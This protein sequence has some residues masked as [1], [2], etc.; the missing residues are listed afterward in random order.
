MEDIRWLAAWCL[1]LTAWVGASRADD[2]PTPELVE[3]RRIWD[4]APHNAFTDLVRWKGRFYCAFREGKGHADDVGKLRIIVSDDAASW[5]SA[6]LLSTG[7]YDLRDAALCVTPDGRLMVLGGAQQTR[8]GGRR[9]GTFVSFSEDGREFSAPKIVVPLG[10][11]LWRVTWHQDIAYGVSYATPDGQPFS[12][13]HK[14]KD[15]VR[16]ETV[17]DQLL[18]EGGWPTEA[19][20]RFGADGTCYCLHRRDGEKSSAFLG[21]A[22]APYKEWKWHDLGQRVGGPNFLQLPSGQWIGAGRLYD[23]GA[24]TELFRL[25]VEQGR[26][27]PLLRLPSGGDTSY[28]GMVWHDNHLWVSYYASHEGKASIYMAKVRFDGEPSAAIHVGNRR[29]LFVDRHVIDRSDGTELRL[30]HPRQAEVVLRFDQPWEGAFC[31]YATVF[32]DD[33]RYRMYYR[34]LP[35]AGRDGTSSEV[36]CY[37]ESSDGIHW[38][39]PKLKLYDVEGSGDNNIVLRGQ[40]PASHNFSPFLDRNPEALSEQKYKALGGTAGGLIAF[41]SADGLRWHRLREEPVFTR[42]VFDSQNVAFWSPSE[43][44]YLCYFR[45]WTETDYGGFRT[46]SRTTSKDFVHWTDPVDM[47]F[48]D[49]PYEHLYTNQTHPYFRAPHLYVGI[50]ARFM[51]GRRVLT[52]RDADQINVHPSYFGDCSDAVL[53]TSRGGGAYQRTFMESFIRPGLGLENWV[54][55]TNYPALGI[56]PTG[57]REMSVYL[58]KNYG[59]PTAHLQRYTMRLDG[60]ASV[61]AR[62]D[63]GEMVTKPITFAVDDEDDGSRKAA[64]AVA[65]QLHLNFS[66]SAAG[67]IRVELQTD[68]GEPIP[69]FSLNDCDPIIGDCLDCIA[70]WKGKSDLQPFAQQPVRLRFEMKDADL[71]SMQIR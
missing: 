18:G 38:E 59:Q 19:R 49:N 29:E 44:Q 23:G 26:M 43:R 12:A 33:D 55:R 25:D 58:Q 53:L 24:R 15:G 54:S 20:L 61:H 57:D 22:A 63:T 47:T 40:T 11:W 3:V 10:R 46:I 42:G 2:F 64:T 48:G 7:D 17:T 13:L 28:P 27:T 34:G 62:Y 6:G 4:E 51:P 67:S 8:D 50:A 69:G 16:Y 30:H 41:A 36:T 66:T 32:K 52:L 65:R 56:V 60:F 45:T 71:Y 5:Q 70:T 21:V 35:S 31:G 37:A 39:K 14:T 9:T 68:I 1:I